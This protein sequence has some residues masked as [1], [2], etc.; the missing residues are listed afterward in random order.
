M[1]KKEKLSEKIKEGVS[2]KEIENFAK[3]YTCEVFSALAI[4]IATISSA[5]NFFTGSVWSVLFAGAG[6]IV[7][8]ILPNQINKTLGKFYEMIKTQ[9]KATQIII[10]IVKLVIAIF[11]PLVLFALLGLLG[12]S[13]THLHSLKSKS[14]QEK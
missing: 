3:K 2:V 8:L 9:E 4:F 6:A 12:G 10:G 11:V 14:Q 13:S 7:A 1:D 5:F